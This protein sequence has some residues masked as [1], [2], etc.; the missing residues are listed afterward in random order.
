[1]FGCSF[2]VLDMYDERSYFITHY[3]DKLKQW[4]HSGDYYLEYIDLMLDYDKSDLQQNNVTWIHEQLC[5]DTS[6]EI[7][8]CV[9][10]KI[11]FLL[12]V[13]VLSNLC[14]TRFCSPRAITRMK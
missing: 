3:L 8:R 10:G 13:S 14:D 7:K 4:A 12:L 2:Y 5:K 11:P 9:D 1:M 6:N